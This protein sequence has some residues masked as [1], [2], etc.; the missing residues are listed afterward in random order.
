MSK[1]YESDVLARESRHYLVDYP[2]FSD[3]L[4]FI[5]TWIFPLAVVAVAAWN[6]YIEIQRRGVCATTVIVVAIAFAL[7]ATTLL[8]LYSTKLKRLL[9]RLS[10]RRA[11]SPS[12]SAGAEP[13]L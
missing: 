7:S 1:L 6:C 3:W 8:F 5:Y 13:S 4:H 12:N 9:S 10:S 11:G 2:A